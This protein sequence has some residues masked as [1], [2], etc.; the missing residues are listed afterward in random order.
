MADGGA[1]PNEKMLENGN[2]DP[3]KKAID[4]AYHARRQ[5]ENERMF[6]WQDEEKNRAGTL[7]R[8]QAEKAKGAGMTAGGMPEGGFPTLP[9]T[10]PKPAGG[11]SPSEQLSRDQAGAANQQ[12]NAAMAG[13]AGGA[14]GAEGAMDPQ[15]QLKK[16]MKGNHYLLQGLQY[17]LDIDIFCWGLTLPLTLPFYD[18]I[19][20]GLLGLELMYSMQGN[21]TPDAPGFAGLLATVGIRLDANTI[22]PPGSNMELSILPKSF[23]QVGAFGFIIIIFLLNVVVYGFVAVIVYSTLHPID[24][25]MSLPDVFSIFSFIGT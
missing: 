11:G 1:Q 15:E 8:N 5:A 2:D 23:L 12:S 21:D 22:T 10:P 9:N 18:T 14:G 3:V 17:L 24:A 4:E 6:A 25:L 19:F 16:Q 13:G 20:I 7:K